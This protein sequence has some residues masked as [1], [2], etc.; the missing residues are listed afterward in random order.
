MQPVK[1]LVIDDDADD[2]DFFEIALADCGQPYKFSPVQ[3]GLKAL[4]LLNNQALTPDFI[5]LDLN[6]PLLS[7]KQCL[8]GIRTIPHLRHVPVVIYSTS[9]YYKDIE[10][11]RRLG[12]TFF[13]TKN[14]DIDSLSRILCD[15]FTGK[16]LPFVLA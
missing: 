15:I 1:C 10:E 3:C 16:Q 4:E 11:T 7:G 6:M 9:S 13:L 5:F 12:A 8:E 14:A 2:R